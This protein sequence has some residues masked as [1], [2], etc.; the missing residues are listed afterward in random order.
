[1]R[2]RRREQAVNLFA[3]QDIITGVAGVMLFVLLLLVVQLS[4]R[5]ANKAVASQSQTETPTQQLTRNQPSAEPVDDPREE[6]ATL[7]SERERLRRDNQELLQAAQRD[8]DQAI[9]N[10]QRELAELVEQAEQ[11]KSQAEALEQQIASQ[12]MDEQRSEILR[13]RSQAR[14]QLE[15]FQRER[16]MHQS[17]KLVAFKTT[18]NSSRAMWVIDLHDSHADLFDVHDPTQVTTVSYDREDMPMATVHQIAD[19]LRSKTNTRSIILVLRP[20]IAGA[21]VMFMSGFRDA[22]FNIALELLDEDSVITQS[23]EDPISAPPGSKQP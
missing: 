22:G 20:S 9:Q 12:E 8:L 13:R 2:R 17:G 7:Q 19:A 5:L 15:A 14:E 6:L 23:S 18:A 3:F 4:L 16:Q 11:T 21:G 10:A 1:M